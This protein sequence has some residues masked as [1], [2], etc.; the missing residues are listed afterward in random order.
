M[1]RVPERYTPGST[2]VREFVH[3]QRV[4]TAIPTRVIADTDRLVVAH[5]RP[6]PDWPTP[7]TVLDI[8]S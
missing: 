7:C 2:V 8:D 5:W 4:W 3:R 6:E 1:T